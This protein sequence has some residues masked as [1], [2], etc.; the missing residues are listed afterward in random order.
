MP[1]SMDFPNFVPRDTRHEYL[2]P[3][4]PDERKRFGL[5]HKGDTF[6]ETTGQPRE[7]VDGGPRYY[8]DHL[9][10]PMKDGAT[11]HEPDSANP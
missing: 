5:P 8:Y 6:P 2:K 7:S 9:D 4:T 11:A 10:S 3:L 1:P